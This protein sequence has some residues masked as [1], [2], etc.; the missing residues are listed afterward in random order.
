[1]PLAQL[2]VPPALVAAMDPFL[3]SVIETGYNRPNP[4]VAGSRPSEPVPFQPVPLPQ[5]WLPDV[6]SVTA[7]AIQSVELLAGAVQPNLIVNKNVS[8]LAAVQP[9]TPSF[10][11]ASPVGDGKPVVEKEKSEPAAGSGPTKLQPAQQ[12]KAGLRPGNLLRSLFPP[13]PAHTTTD[14]KGSTPHSP[15]GTAW[16]IR[17]CRLAFLVERNRTPHPGSEGLDFSC[18]PFG[19]L[20]QFQ[21]VCKPTQRNPSAATRGCGAVL[22]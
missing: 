13:K 16:L 1:M 3:R 14:P 9:D 4:N 22:T 15:S 10:T 17:F 5:L 19:P 21:F 7:G 18:H 6:L 12:S 2:G 8:T 11:P 20:F